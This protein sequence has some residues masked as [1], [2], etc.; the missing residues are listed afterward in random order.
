ML[1]PIELRAHWRSSYASIRAHP[2]EAM[3]GV[4]RIGSW[5]AKPPPAR[6]DGGIGRYRC[7]RTVGWRR[8]WDLNPR[9]GST[10]HLLSREAHST[11]LWHLSRCE[12]DRSQLGPV[13]TPLPHRV[14]QSDPQ[15]PDCQRHTGGG[16]DESCNH[17]TVAGAPSVK[18]L[19][20]P[21]GPIWHGCLHQGRSQ[22]RE[23]HDQ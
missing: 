22:G 4:R 17:W 15:P 3:S 14:G 20:D 16:D 19:Q 7:V 10:P 21:L 6:T 1:Y 8:G 23:H 13:A 18:T 11:G 9:R 2:K 5:Q 12:K